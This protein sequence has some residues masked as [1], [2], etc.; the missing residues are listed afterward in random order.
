MAL[1]EG[2]ERISGATREELMTGV[3]IALDLLDDTVTVHQQRAIR[4][5]LL[6]PIVHPERYAL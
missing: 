5:A 3:L 4:R 2:R 6:D 1:G